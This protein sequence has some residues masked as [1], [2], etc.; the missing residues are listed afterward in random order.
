MKF[1]IFVILILLIDFSMKKKN[2]NQYYLYNLIVY[3]QVIVAINAIFKLS[4]INKQIWLILKTLINYV[5]YLVFI[6]FIVHMSLDQRN[7]KQDSCSQ[8]RIYLI[9]QNG[10]FTNRTSLVIVSFFSDQINITCGPCAP[11][12]NSH[13]FKLVSI[14]ICI[15]FFFSLCSLYLGHSCTFSLFCA[16]V[17]H[18]SLTCQGCWMRNP[19]PTL[20]AS[21]WKSPLV[22]SY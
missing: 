16:M 8:I 2:L 19:T 11:I 13:I 18:N 6:I 15:F 4:C 12:N 1:V 9:I 14:S 7:E 21:S 22:Y 20:K 10:P 5:L 3:I 17:T